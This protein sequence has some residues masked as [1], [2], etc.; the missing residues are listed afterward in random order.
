VRTSGGSG[1]VTEHADAACKQG[2]R[3]RNGST[4]LQAKHPGGA[5][6]AVTGR[7]Q[8]SEGVQNEVRLDSRVMSVK[9]R[10]S[11][12]RACESETARFSAQSSRRESRAISAAITRSHLIPL[13][14]PCFASSSIAPLDQPPE[15]DLPSPDSSM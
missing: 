13:F 9:H 1:T 6:Q 3:V 7:R 2:V 12:R 10:R 5:V 8:V 14:L 4:T 15:A 11:H